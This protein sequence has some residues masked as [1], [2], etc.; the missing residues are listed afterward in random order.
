[1]ALLPLCSVF[2]SPQDPALVCMDVI[3]SVRGG[4]ESI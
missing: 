3:I 2:N 4:G 1:M